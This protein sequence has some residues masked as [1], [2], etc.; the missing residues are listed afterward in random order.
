MTRKFL[1]ITLVIIIVFSFELVGCSNEQTAAP[2]TQTEAKAPANESIWNTDEILAQEP[3]MLRDKLLEAVGATDKPIPYTYEEVVKFTGQSDG[4]TAGAWMMS[5]MALEVLYPDSIPVRG[6]IKIYAPGPGDENHMGVF[7]EIFTYITGAQT[8]IGFSGSNFGE[9]YGKSNRM[10]YPEEESGIPFFKVEWIWERLDTGKKVGVIFNLALI[11]P[12]VTA[13]WEALGK[14]IV[15]GLASPEEIAQHTA[16]WQSRA[17]YVFENART[18]P[19][20]I[21]VREIN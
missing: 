6:D 16:Y 8:E 3:I 5:V 4:A 19:G 2:Q 17:P 11:Q 20:F 10:I 15:D 1:I 9:A 14:K 7:G 13:E 18:L 12:K 21:T